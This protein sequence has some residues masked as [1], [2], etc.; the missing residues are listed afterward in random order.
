MVHISVAARGSGPKD[1]RAGKMEGKR[2]WGD[3]GGEGA[4][5]PNKVSI[6]TNMSG[7]GGQNT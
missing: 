3:R 7:V 6:K 2:L 4:V 1:E 5:G